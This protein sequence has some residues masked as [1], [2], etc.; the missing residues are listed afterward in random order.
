MNTSPNF[1]ARALSTT[2]ATGHTAAL[3]FSLP[4]RPC[5][6]APDP[7]PPVQ[8]WAV[9]TTSMRGRLE[10]DALLPPFNLGVGDLIETAVTGIG[11]LRN[12]V[13]AKKH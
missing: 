4:S 8:S 2:T 5:A 10:L 13:V 9:S 1:C 6:Q 11:V 3:T 12:R 7:S